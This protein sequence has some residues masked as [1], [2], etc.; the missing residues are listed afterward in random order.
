[1]VV[2]E[3]K[4]HFYSLVKLFFQNATVIWGEVNLTKPP[5]PLVA[6]RLDRVT[7]SSHSI[8]LLNEGRVVNYYP[9]KAKIYVA[10]FTKGKEV[11]NEEQ[12]VCAINTAVN[13][14]LDLADFINSPYGV[15]F[16]MKKDFYITPDEEVEDSSALLNDNFWEYKA[17]LGVEVD[18]TQE[19]LGD[20]GIGRFGAYEN[21]SGGG[22]S[23]LS[24][25]QS[26]YFTKVEVEKE[27]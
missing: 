22:S 13:D 14:L 21:S 4:E 6:L 19:S 5:L 10:L 7:R 2:N 18:F 23:D 1:M 11:I 9:S 26:G 16:A 8:T 25:E 27:D 17:V 20:K 12:G 3:L 24:L 15:D